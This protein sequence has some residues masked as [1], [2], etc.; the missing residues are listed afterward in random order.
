M[1]PNVL[2]MQFSFPVSI[3]D[4]MTMHLYC[5]QVDYLGGRGGGDLGTVVRTVMTEL[6]GQG[7][8]TR[9][10]WEGRGKKIGFQRFK[11]AA[12]AMCKSYFFK[13]IVP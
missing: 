12:C 8:A 1:K 11:V 9:M 4:V 6:I 2:H 3:H 7:M 5:F 10:N 13:S